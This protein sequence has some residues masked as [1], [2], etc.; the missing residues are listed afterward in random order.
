MRHKSVAPKH[1]QTDARL[2]LD[3]TLRLWLVCLI[4]IPVLITVAWGDIYSDAAY[5]QFSA[6]RALARG[7]AEAVSIHISPLYIGLLALAHR[8]RLALPSVGAIFSMLGWML[9]VIAWFFV[10][11]N[12]ESR[13]FAVAAAGL[14]ALHP[15]HPQVL[16]LETGLVLAALG[17]VVLTGMQDLNRPLYVGAMMSTVLFLVA[18][19]PL[20]LLLASP[21][22]V[23]AL[24][25]R[26][27]S[28]VLSDQHTPTLPKLLLLLILWAIMILGIGWRG[29]LRPHLGVALW[30]VGQLGFAA[31]FAW[32]VPDIRWL[33]NPVANHATF[34]RGIALV[35]LISLLLLQAIALLNA[36]RARPVEQL[37][38]YKALAAWLQAH[39]LPDEVVGTHRVGLIGYLA[40]RTTVALPLDS[41]NRG[42]RALLTALDDTRPDY[43]LALSGVA[44]NG[45][46]AQPWFQA[47]Y[48]MIHRE[49]S[50]Y[51]LPPLMLFRYTPSPFDTGERRSVWRPFYDTEHEVLREQ[52]ISAENP[53]SQSGR[54]DWHR[55]ELLDYRL[56]HR[57]I[58]PGK[59]VYLTLYW[60]PEAAKASGSKGLQMRL[61]L[62]ARDT[63]QVWASVVSSLSDD[64]TTEFWK[65]EA[66]LGQETFGERGY[67]IGR[68]VLWP[69]EEIPEGE[70][71]LDIALQYQNGRPLFVRA[72]GTTE[73][74][75]IEQDKHSE[76]TVV[77]DHLILTTL[78]HP[79]D[80]SP[81]PFTPDHTLRVTL[82]TSEGDDAHHPIALVG[83]DAP[84]RAAPGDT[85]RIALYW[86]TPQKGGDD[87]ATIDGQPIS[88]DY[89]VFVH[90]LS[91]EGEMVALEDSKPVYWFYPTNM[92]KPGEY[93]RDEHVLALSPDIPRGD[94]WITV[95]MY[96]PESGE[97]LEIRADDI[98]PDQ[99]IKLQR[100]KIR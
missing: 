4:L 78:Y 33:Y 94:Y 30:A 64:L 34:R 49:A 91:P 86:H 20:W 8:G 65:L 1:K 62:I 29:A 25:P 88:G 96:D 16:G 61:K 77:Q 59:P 24:L 5:A 73:A 35:I 11:L 9:A 42:A 79:P 99:R 57:R 70:Y 47:R 51:A 53:S 7:N 66:H 84:E 23:V 55:L 3:E 87:G 21:I 45:V 83:Y 38:L 17:G 75:A 40:D 68:H 48:Q 72:M 37:R 85:I 82:G 27:S 19:H 60:S 95:G 2:R 80:I 43:C 81:V 12:I 93:I 32:L 97:R 18:L 39:A 50:P 76:D 58:T 15:L 28:R 90:I 100:L 89:K 67:L 98:T 44:W 31:G 52:H 6:A 41:A 22:I 74:K 92:W 69:P 63:R 71:D 54:D 26:R 46:R 14:L 36:W 56:S 13:H 10:G